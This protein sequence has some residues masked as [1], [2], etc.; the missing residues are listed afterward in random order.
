[1]IFVAFV[2]AIGNAN[3]QKL[4]K[5]LEFTYSAQSEG[6]KQKPT[7]YEAKAGTQ[8]LGKLRFTPK[9]DSIELSCEYENQKGKKVR[10]EFYSKGKK[11][12]QTVKDASNG[13]NGE[14]SSHFIEQYELVHSSEIAPA[15]SIWPLL[16]AYCTKFRGYVNGDGDWEA[17]VIWDCGRTTD[18]STSGVE[19]IL[20]NK[21]IPNVDLIKFIQIPPRNSTVPV[22]DQVFRLN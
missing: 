2:V 18:S 6:E 17:E 15:L 19:V 4:L 9:G 14:I 3:G 22:V 11:V 21:R 5:K 1:M 13:P 20:A 7:V 12:H 16:V 10:I 8:T